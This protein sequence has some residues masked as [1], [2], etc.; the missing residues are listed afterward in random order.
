VLCCAVLCCAVLC[1]A[2]LCCA[3]LCCAVLCCAVRFMLFTG[4]CGVCACLKLLSGFE[5]PVRVLVV[6]ACRGVVGNEVASCRGGGGFA[7]RWADWLRHSTV[8]WVQSCLAGVTAPLCS[9]SPPPA[10]LHHGPYSVTFNGT[11]TQTLRLDY[12]HFTGDSALQL[13][14]QPADNKSAAP[15][16]VPGTAFTPLMTP[17]EIERRVG[18]AP[19][20]S[21]VVVV[22]SAFPAFGCQPRRGPSS[23][24]TVVSHP[25]PD[26]HPRPRRAVSRPRAPGA[27]EPA[28]EPRGTVAN[29]Q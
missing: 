24:S 29:V 21:C 16:P 17:F 7:Y 19:H 1:C 18:F 12:I 28:D 25:L 3:V 11:A 9:P 5:R 4:P 27:A 15:L 22:P 10:L 13:L 26:P 6:G 8:R 2:V 23:L 14:W 20:P